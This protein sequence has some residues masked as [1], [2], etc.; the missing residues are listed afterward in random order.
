MSA[1]ELVTHAAG[2]G[3]RML[4]PKAREIIA[5]SADA[6]CIAPGQRATAETILAREVAA[7]E[8]LYEE[9]AICDHAL[10]AL[11][12]DTPAAVLCSIPGVGV[13]TASYYGAA[14][15]DPARFANAESAYRYSGLSPSS[16]DSAG[17]TGRPS[18]SREGNV[19]LRHAII[20]L[21]QGVSMHHPDF[22]AYKKRLMAA[23][24][25][26]LVALIAVGHRAHRLAFAMLRSQQPF[27]D[28]RW[29]DAVAK[30]RPVTT[31]EVIGTT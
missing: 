2:H 8:R 16:Y 27:D 26:P 17:R 29:T 23:G 5:A 24:K 21:G 22:I 10:G 3:R 20:T 14:L 1:D 9:L 13:L 11:I 25:R 31:N 18:I 7:L 30:G 6:Q 4:R 28:Q 15:G 12:H 19:A